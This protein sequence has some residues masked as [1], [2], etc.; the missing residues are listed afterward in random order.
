[1][2]ELDLNEMDFYCADI[3]VISHSD[4]LLYSSCRTL[5]MSVNCQSANLP[6]CLGTLEFRKT[7]TVLIQVLTEQV[8]KVIFDNV[9]HIDIFP[10]TKTNALVI[11]TR[12]II[13]RYHG[14][15]GRK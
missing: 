9:H 6:V 10:V 14:A 5:S 3:C 7:S 2:I 8:P 1:M 15:K 4:F 13:V 12:K 11:C